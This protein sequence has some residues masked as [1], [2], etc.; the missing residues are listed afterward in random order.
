[1]SDTQVLPVAQML[2]N[3]LRTSVEANPNVPSHISFRIGDQVG[4]DFGPMVDECCE[5]LAYVSMGDVV[6]SVT[7]PAADV[8]R[9]AAAKCSPP[10]WVVTLKAGIVRCAPAGQ[11]D[12][13]PPTDVE[14]TNAFI[15]SANDSQA[16]RKAACCFRNCIVT[17]DD[18][19]LLGMSV[20]IDAQTQ[21]PVSGGC[22]ERFFTVRF[23][24]P[25]QDCCPCSGC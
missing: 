12:G 21:G 6:P 10:S 4:H 2:L 7:A 25:N 16:L 20:V 23:Q 15:Q 9:Q 5:G 24:I 1:M 19:N 8:E 3:C 17:S 22:M 11:D 13:D 14:W 18:F